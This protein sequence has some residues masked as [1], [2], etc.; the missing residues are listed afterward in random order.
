MTT[1]LLY[2]TVQTGKDKRKKV[3]LPRIPCQPVS[4]YFPVPVFYTSQ[5]PIRMC[6][7]VTTDRAQGQSFRGKI[8]LDI[9][10]DSFAD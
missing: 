4:E 2:L 6:F 9:T 7:G 3:I 8:G 1:R 5:L 10:D